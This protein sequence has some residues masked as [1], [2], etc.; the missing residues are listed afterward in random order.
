[1]NVLSAEGCERSRKRCSV[2]TGTRVLIGVDARTRWGRRFRALISGFV[3]E[4]G[5]RE[6]LTEVD[7]AVIRSAAS[8]TLKC[9]MLQAN[10]VNG[11]SVDPDEIVRLSS[12]G[13]R[14][15]EA[16]RKR[17]KPQAQTTLHD[18][19]AGKGAAA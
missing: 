1:M 14:A 8:L 16:V 17:S 12:E 9:E 5:G 15:L 13:R 4:A 7:M 18:Y 2:A 3:S 19:L 10:L 11:E 6:C